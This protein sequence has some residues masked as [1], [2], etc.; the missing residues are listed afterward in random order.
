MRIDDHVGAEGAHEIAL[1]I[2]LHHRV[3]VAGKA[4]VLFAAARDPDGLA[5]DVDIDGAGGAQFAL[6]G[7]HLQPGFV[8]VVGI[9]QVDVRPLAQRQVIVALRNTDVEA[10]AADRRPRATG[11]RAAE[12]S[13]LSRGGGGDG[14]A[15]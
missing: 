8:T 7:R 9:G 1:L 14:A 4:T 10:R 2:E 15:P 13:G 12:V 3:D 6:A 5:V 11:R